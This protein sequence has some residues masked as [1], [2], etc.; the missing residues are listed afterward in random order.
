MDAPVTADEGA[1][2]GVGSITRGRRGDVIVRSGFIS[3][4]LALLDE[5]SMVVVAGGA[6][7]IGGVRRH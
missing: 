6:V 5:I 4:A 2:S 7:G 3:D 1:R